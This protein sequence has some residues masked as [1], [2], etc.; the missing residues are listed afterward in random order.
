M[1]L[2]N[3]KTQ[4]C[5]IFCI[6]YTY[7]NQC[8]TFNDSI[9]YTQSGITEAGEEN[10]PKT[11]DQSTD[12]PKPQT[13][14]KS[15]D[16]SNVDESCDLYLV[17]ITQGPASNKNTEQT[18]I[19]NEKCETNGSRHKPRGKLQD[20]QKSSSLL[21][22]EASRDAGLSGNEAIDKVFAENIIDKVINGHHNRTKSLNVQSKAL[23]NTDPNHEESQK[24]QVNLYRAENNQNC[25]GTGLVSTQDNSSRGLT[26][27]GGGHTIKVGNKH[28][29]KISVMKSQNLKW[30]S[31]K[32]SLNLPNH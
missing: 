2:K 26:D 31:K 16:V 29:N 19:P 3:F 20:T 10:H 8:E 9:L 28:P 7:D 11:L 24:W 22:A 27:S 14:L 32:N 4:L 15:S 1:R 30:L 18:C 25:D 5:S 17:N 13:P 21:M 23:P 6:S 12:H